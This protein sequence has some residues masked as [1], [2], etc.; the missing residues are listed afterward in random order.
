MGIEQ[1]GRISIFYGFDSESTL[2]K[3]DLIE[4]EVKN[5][6]DRG[7]TF[8]ETVILAETEFLMPGLVSSLI[9]YRL[10]LD[11]HRCYNLITIGAIVIIIG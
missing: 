2:F 1:S 9:T 7:W 3:T 8:E 11:N 10:L 5:L 6:K 4:K